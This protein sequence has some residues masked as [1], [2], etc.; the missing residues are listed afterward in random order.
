MSHCSQS[1]RSTLIFS[2]ST[3]QPV[4]SVSALSQDSRTRIFGCVFCSPGQEKRKE[5]RG[6]KYNNT[7]CMVWSSH[8]ADYVGRST[9]SGFANPARG[10]LIRENVFFLYPRS[11]LRIWPRETGSTV[12]SRVSLLISTLRL[13]LMLTHGIP[14]R[15]PG[16]RHSPLVRHSPFIYTVNNNSIARKFWYKVHCFCRRKKNLN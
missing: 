7:L 12:P 3:P 9:G 16:R 1:T 8:I 5:K 13:N 4:L 6:I 10:Q 15:F 11:R 14:S 2:L